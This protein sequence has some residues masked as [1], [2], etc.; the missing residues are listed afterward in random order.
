MN[1]SLHP[2]LKECRAIYDLE[3]VME[4][5]NCYVDLMTKKTGE[6]LPLGDFSPMGKRQKEFLDRLLAIDAEELASDACRTV[7]KE[8]DSNDSFRVMLVVVDEPAN[9]W[10]QRFLTDADWRFTD[11][12]AS[13]PKKN[14]PAFDRWV[15]V[16][17]WTTDSN[18]QPMIATAESV[19]RSTREALF[20]AYWQRQYGIPKTLEETLR[21]EGATLNFAG[22]KVSYS[23]QQI[24]E[25]WNIVSPFL[26][27]KK[28]P[29][30]FAAMYGDEAALSSGYGCLG[31]KLNAGFQ[32]AIILVSVTISK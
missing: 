6:I 9:G 2:I 25:S 7:C 11:K 15:T 17:L 19:V 28:F 10:T 22:E 32:V 30:I 27:S 12:I 1:V 31:L 24:T 8:I 21:Q 4:R 16:N 18:M 23:E 3:G 26:N 5:F 29:E 14:L 20:R 13:L